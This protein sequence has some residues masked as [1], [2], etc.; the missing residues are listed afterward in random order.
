MSE[1][2][3]TLIVESKTAPGMVAGIIACVLA[4]LGILFLGTVFV[5]IAAF[6]ATFGTII[7]VKNKNN[8]GIGVNVLA[9]VLTIVGVYTS[10]VLWGVFHLVTGSQPL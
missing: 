7:A 6:V 3:E 8:A 10:P 5:P 9:W 4:I 2:Q 1:G